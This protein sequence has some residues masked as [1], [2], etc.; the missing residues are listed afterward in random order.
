MNEPVS[1]IFDDDE[2]LSREIEPI[3][4]NANQADAPGEDVLETSPPRLPGPGFLESIAWTI[5]AMMIQIVGSVCAIFVIFTLYVAS[6][7]LPEQQLKLKLQDDSFLM[8]LMREYPGTN[9]GITM[10]VFFLGVATVVGLRLGSHRRRALPLQMPSPWHVFLTLLWVLPLSLISGQ[11]GL[12]ADLGWNQLTQLFPSLQGMDGLNVMESIGEII[13]G[14]PVG[15]VFVLIA[16]FPA[17]TEELLFRVLIGRGLVARYGIVTG[18]A[19]TTLLFAAVHMHPVHMVALLPL[20]VAIH[21]SYLASRSVWIP[22]LAHFLNNALAVS[23]LLNFDPEEVPAGVGE[24]FLPWYV[25]LTAAIFCVMIGWMYWQSRLV[26]H[27]EE[28]APISEPYIS[29]DRNHPLWGLLDY[30]WRFPPQKTMIAFALSMGFFVA[31]M[32]YFGQQQ[33]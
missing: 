3:S 22:M 16:V 30:G 21:V 31:S 32:M 23:V 9:L 11:L 27:D 6:A 24:E 20:S 28:L 14:M 17:V 1:P 4:T 13:S 26:L 2:E 7:E 18:I 25:T 33:I 10:I 29:A 12:F 5:L 8:E 19:L 15:L